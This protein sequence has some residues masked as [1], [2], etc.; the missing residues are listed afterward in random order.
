[1]NARW[2]YRGVRIAAI[3]TAA[4]AVFGFVVKGLWN[5]LVPSIFGWHT[6]T[7]WQGVG[8]LV[9]SKILFGGGFRGRGGM[10]GMGWRRRMGERWEKM[11]P[12][13]REQFSR[14]MRGCFGRRGFRPEEQKV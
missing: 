1:M 14:G 3:A 7:F 8:L 12:E 6:I 13:E 10:G 2:L 4:V 5:A 11:S 9:L